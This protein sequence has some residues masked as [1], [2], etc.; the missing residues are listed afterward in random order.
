[1]FTT[2][3][4]DEFSIPKKYLKMNPEELKKRC[5][6]VIKNPK[7]ISRGKKKAFDKSVSGDTTFYV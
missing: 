1:M 3:E 5:A 2:Y 6:Q 4:K 7:H